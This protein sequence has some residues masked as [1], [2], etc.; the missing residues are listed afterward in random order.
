MIDLPTIILALI[1]GLIGSLIGAIATS[2]ASYKFNI[3]LCKEEYLFKEKTKKYEYIREII[4]NL[5]HFYEK[6]LFKIDKIPNAQ[7]EQHL[8]NMLKNMEHTMEGYHF[9]D[10]SR[11]DYLSKEIAKMLHNYK[12]KVRKAYEQIPKTLREVE[13][14]ECNFNESTNTISEQIN[15]EIGIKR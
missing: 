8:L 11:I 2:Y 4:S 1:S 3:K 12:E 15:R 6:E 7:R 14:L 5:S 9:F 13:D 10:Y